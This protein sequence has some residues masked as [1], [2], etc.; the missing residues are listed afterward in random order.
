MC[1]CAMHAGGRQR[2]MGMCVPDSCCCCSEEALFPAPFSRCLTWLSSSSLILRSLPAAMMVFMSG[3][4]ATPLQAQ[5]QVNILAQHST[6][7]GRWQEVIAR[8]GRE[9]GAA[10]PCGTL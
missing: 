4:A 3:V 7:Q 2:T 6:A 8:L 10:H 1:T 5:Q 9:N